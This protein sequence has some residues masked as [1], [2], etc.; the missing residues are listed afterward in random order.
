MS[1]IKD[2]ALLEFHRSLKPMGGVSGLARMASVG[3]AHL[4]Q[5]LAGDRSGVNTWKHII[6]RLSERHVELLKL[7]PGWNR[8]AEEEFQRIKCAM[9]ESGGRALDY[10]SDG[11]LCYVER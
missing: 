2:R 11:T 5:V 9:S 4:C 3:R 10:V 8:K 7:C 6:P 1:G